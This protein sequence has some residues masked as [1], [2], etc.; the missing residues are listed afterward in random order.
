MDAMQSIGIFA[1]QTFLILF[2]IL[3]V[4]IVIAIIAAKAGHK[5]EVEVELLHKKY[6]GFRNLLKAHTVSKSERKELKKKLKEE[7]KANDSKAQGHE[8]KIFVVDFEGD[9]KASAV[10]N[11]REE[12]TAVLTIATPQ[13]EVVVRVES[14]GGVVHGYGLCASQ[15][16]RVREKNIPLTVCVD[17]VAASGGY[18]MSVTAN[19]ILCAPFAIVGSIGVVAQVPNLHRVLKKH[20]VDFKEYTAG[21]YKRTVSLLGEITPKGEEKFKQQLE[22][23]HVLF[24]GFVGKFR[25]QLNLEQVATGEYWYGEQAISMGLV[26]E[27]RT[28]DDYLMTLAEKHQVIKVSFEQKQ[29]LSDKLTGILGKAIKKGTLSIVEELETRRFL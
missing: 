27:I 8:K 21:E 10:E 16:M 18:L 13:D 23:T 20:D 17:K 7:R 26:D 28:S 25:P 11:L 29:S 1:A 6:K 9:V 15:L 24:K 22:E 2:A 5:P 19:K 3:A 14:P 4:I 12:I